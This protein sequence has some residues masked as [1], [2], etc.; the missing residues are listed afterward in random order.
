MWAKCGFADP[1]SKECRPGTTLLY[2]VALETTDEL[3]CLHCN[4]N[5][6]RAYLEH[7]GETAFT[8]TWA[9][10]LSDLNLLPSDSSELVFFCFDQ[11]YLLNFNIN[12]FYQSLMT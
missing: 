5:A 12:V 1:S 2:S 9:K 6:C 4:R 11:K 8:A 7:A 10:Y 3:A